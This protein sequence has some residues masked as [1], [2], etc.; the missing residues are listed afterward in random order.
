MKIEATFTQRDS[1]SMFSYAVMGM[2]MRDE[3]RRS[4]ISIRYVFEDID[5]D[6]AERLWGNL[7]ANCR[8]NL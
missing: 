5:A 8:K 6:Q 3:G 7:Y 1:D 2:D 4:H